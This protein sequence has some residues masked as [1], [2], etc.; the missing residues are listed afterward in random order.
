[1]KEHKKKLLKN[2]EFRKEYKRFDLLFEIEQF[3]LK[4]RCWLNMKFRRNK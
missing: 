2:P 4:A 1:M 3:I